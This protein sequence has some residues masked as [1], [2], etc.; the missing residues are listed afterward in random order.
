MADKQLNPVLAVL[1]DQ[2]RADHAAYH[3]LREGRAR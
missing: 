1:L 2:V 3:R